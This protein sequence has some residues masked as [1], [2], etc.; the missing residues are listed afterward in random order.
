MTKLKHFGKAKL[1]LLSALCFLSITAAQAQV[2]K[3][4]GGTG[5]ADYATISAAFTAINSGLITGNI[6]LNVISSTTEPATPVQLNASTV[7]SASYTSVLIKPTATATINSAASP[8]SGKGVI[9]FCGADN[10]TIDGAIAAGG[11]TQDLTIAIA[12]INV[13]QA[14]IRLAGGTTSPAF[15]CNNIT[16]K[17]CKIVGNAT[18]TTFTGVFG[19]AAASGYSSTTNT[20]TFSSAGTSADPDNL[21]ITNNLITKCYTGIY[22]KAT[23]GNLADNLVIKGNTIGSA[24]SGSEVLFRGIDV[25]YTSTTANAGGVIDGNDI[26]VKQSTAL[27]DIA[28]IQLSNCTNTI[29]RGNKLHDIINANTSGYG[30]YGIYLIVANSGVEISN[31]FIY[32]IL[33]YR[34]SS[35]APPTMSTGG[36]DHAIGVNLEVATNTKIWSNTINLYGAIPGTSNS[37]SADIALLSNTSVTGTDIRNNVLVN[38]QTTSTSSRV[39][40][41]YAVSGVTFTQSNYNIYWVGATAGTAPYFVGLLGTDRTNLAAWQG[42]T[43]K[44]GNSLMADPLLVS[45]TNLHITSSSSPAKAAGSNPGVYVDYD[46]QTRGTSCDIGADEF[47]PTCFAT[48]PVSVSGI[49]QFAANLSWSAANTAPS[50]GYDIYYSTSSTAP[51]GA[52]TPSFSGVSGLTQ[53][54]SGLTP[55]TLYYVWIR[56]NCGGTQ[57]TWS[58]PTQFTSLANPCVTPTANTAGPLTYGTVTSTSIPVTSF[59]AASPAADGY[60]V[61]YSTSSTLSSG[62]VDGTTY[63]AGNA[64]G[65][66]TVVQANATTAFTIS[67]LSAN[68]LYYIFIYSYNNSGCSGGPKY[69]ATAYSTSKLTCAAAATALAGTATGQTTA[70]IT[71]T[72]PTGASSWLLEYKPTSGST[73]TTASPAPTGSPYSLT[74]LS[75]STTYDIR[76]TASNASC[77]T[78]VTTTSAF[79]TVCGAV[80]AGW[81]EGFETVTPGSGAGTGTY[82]PNCW[83]EIGDWTSATGTVS[84]YRKPRTGNQ[85][86]Y[87]QWSADDWLFS[88]LTTLTGGVSYDFTY[89]YIA[90]NNGGSGTTAFATELKYGTA[91]TA[92]GMTNAI[93]TLT[94][95]GTT[96]TFVKVT[97]T[98][99]PATTG[100]YTVGIHVFVNSVTPNYISFDDISLTQT[101]PCPTAPTIGTITTTS[102]T[103][104]VPFTCTSCAGTFIAEYST[105]SGFTPGTGATAGGGTVTSPVSSTPITING[106]SPNTTYYVY[107]RNNCSGAFY[108]PNS[109]VASFTT[110]C[111][112]VAVGWTEGFE[113]VTPGSGAGTGTY[114]PTCWSEIGDWTSATGV[115]STYRQPRTGNQFIYTN[116]TADDWLFTAPTTLTA[117]VS[118]DFT[119]YYIVDNN[120]GTGTSAFST[121][122]KYGTAQTVAGMTNTITTLANVA[123]TSTYTKVTQSFTPSVSGDYSIGIHVYVNST[124]PNYFSFDD[125]SLSVTPACSLAPTPGTITTTPVSATI[126]FTCSACTGTFIAEYSTT[127]GFTPGTGATAGGGTVTTPV[128]SSP[129][130]LSSLSPNTTYYVYLRNNCSGSTYSPNSSVFSFTTPCVAANVPYSES[131]DLVTQPALPSCYSIE[132]TNADAN[133]WKTCTSTSLGNLTAVTPRSGTNQMGIAYNTGAAMNDWFF[134]PQLNLTGGTS[135]RLTFWARGYTGLTE[136]LEVKYGTAASSASMTSGTIL[137]T[138]SIVGGGVYTQYTADF[139]PASSGT[140][141]IGFHGLSASNQWYLFVDDIAVNLTPACP[142]TPTIGTP[143]VTAT[144][145]TLPFTCTSCSGTFI[146]EYS[147]SS[148]FTPGTG[149]TAGGGTVTAPVSGT[150]ITI[151]GLTPNTTYYAYVRN[152]CSGSNYSA[153]SSVVSFTTYL[154]CSTATPLSCGVAGS[155]SV[156]GATGATAYNFSGTSPNN[157]CGNATP[158]PEQF[159][160][161]TPA[162]TGPYK[163]DGVKTGTAN[164]S[165]LYKD[166]SLGCGPTGWTCLGIINNGGF[167]NTIT[168]TGGV[169]YLIIVDN[170]SAVN[171]ATGTITVTCPCS[172]TPNA[173]TITQTSPQYFCG[174]TSTVTL[175]ATGLSTTPGISYQWEESDDNGVSDP[176]A[177]AVGGSGA[178]TANYTSPAITKTLYYRL[179]STCSTSGLSATTAPFQAIQN[180][181][182]TVSITPSV[183]SVC[184]GVGTSVTL[185][186]T[187]STG[188]TYSWSNSLGST[189][190]VSVVPSITSTYTVSATVTAT[191]C[192]ATASTTITVNPAPPVTTGASVCPGGSATIS[193]SSTC[194][195][196]VN[197][198]T[199]YSGA[200][201]GATDPTANRIT[202]SLSN[203]TTCSFSSTVYNRNYVAQQFQV[204]VTGSYTL[205]MTDNTA[206]DGMAYITTGAFVPGNCAGGGTWIVGDDDGGTAGNEPLMT[207]TLTAGVTYT[208]VS[209][210]YALSSGTYTG[211]FS[212]TITPPSGG[213]I[214]LPGTVNMNWYTA[215]FGG[216]PVATGSTINP[217]TLSLVNSNISGTTIFYAA[218]SSNNTCRTATNFVVYNPPVVAPTASP[219]TICNGAASTISAGAT[220]GSNPITTYAWSSGLA[221][222]V[223][224]G[225]VAPTTNSSYTVTVTDNKSCTSTGTIAVNVITCGANTWL[226]GSSDWHTAGNWSNGF[227]P[228][229]CSHDV[230]IPVTPNNPV[231]ST[232]VNVG[233]VQLQNGTT[234]TLNANLNVCGNFSG[235]ASTVAQVNGSAR[236]V[237]SGSSAQQLS[238]KLEVN[239]LRLNN[240]A[241]ASLQAGASVD[242]FDAVELQTGVLSTGS[243]T[244]RFRSTSPSQ[245]AI[246]NNF[247]P[248]FTGSLSGNATAQRFV[249]VGG[250]NQHYFGTPVTNATFGQLGATGVPGYVLPTYNCDQTQ[251]AINSPYGTVY[252][253]HDDKPLNAQCLYNGWEVKI[254]GTTQAG[255]GYSTFLSNGVFSITGN[256]NQG[257]SYS[258]NGM[259]NIGWT[260][261]TLQTYGFVPAAYE[262]GWHIVANP[263]LAP[264]TLNGHTPDFDAA[265]IWVTSGPFSGSYQPIPI[266]GGSIAPFQGFIVHRSSSSSVN[267]TFNKSECTTSAGQ[268][269]YKQ[270]SQHAMNIQ[271]SGNGFNDITY[272]EFNS[273]ATNTYDVGYD[274]RKP[275]SVLGQPTI[276]TF[277]T[278]NAE[279]L[280]INVNRS[281]DETPNVPMNFI[282]G[283]NGTFTFTADGVNSFDP[284]SYVFLEDKQT[285]QWIDLRQNA[286]YTFQSTTADA[287]D[288]F[289]L[290]FTPAA[291]LSASDASCATMGQ[292]TIEQPG[293]AN[294]NYTVSNQNNVVIASGTLNQNNSV[295]VS[296][297]AGVYQLT[298]VDNSGY[299]VVKNVQV[300]GVQTIAA[301][302]TADKNTV[303][304]AQDV[305]FT[306][307]TANA[308]TTEWNFGDGATATTA[309]ATH[310]YQSEGV[311]TVS[312]TVTNADGCSSTVQQTITVTAKEA[313]GINNLD[314][315]A[316]RM[317]SNES[318]I[319]IDFSKVKQVK[320]SIAIYNVLGQ[321]LLEDTWTK[322]SI[323]TKTL[324][325]L[326][327]A[328]ILVHVNNNGKM[329]TEKLF[330]TGTK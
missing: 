46:A 226:G 205:E 210:T 304:T 107:L 24:T 276:F 70:T 173:G 178:T 264:L 325:N 254:S 229:L 262:S 263:Y 159:F 321:K 214:M 28:G 270:A 310:Q 313:T 257:A 147:T 326:D 247:G 289:V 72:N 40:A 55:S 22:V 133:V 302:M 105:S 149:A 300:N 252:Q 190:S 69:F 204:S 124:T 139:I 26:Q 322:S 21:T 219:V 153:N 19:I 67:S 130:S 110:P 17:N 319:F 293:T 216:S 163:F 268:T 181:N 145:A 106:L 51:T 315:D 111:A 238:G 122:L 309:T 177:N 292:I 185:S 195:G 286:T 158:G 297:T 255:R 285:G 218:C 114:L 228:T 92:A 330:I 249:P 93:T 143:A 237:L 83:S 20:S 194:S 314:K 148:G 187:P 209:T 8:T 162:V 15:G 316:I 18:G 294:W 318:N 135:Y 192:S 208:L 120:A 47:S 86:I 161:F 31:N 200:W 323:Y 68:T 126:P 246:L 269:F 25:Q 4:V 45:S 57:S 118:Y 84:T 62:P 75:A 212:W 33:G 3:T 123:T 154:D 301:A 35:T 231:V 227:V 71:W 207:T 201:N 282:P 160:S 267:F 242:V 217:V 284:T 127:S 224:S 175:N 308:A 43:T 244:L 243:A 303:E 253:W 63:A 156:A 180:A 260:S 58:G 221:G 215:S 129:I 11:S 265:A 150:P 117:G 324:S 112:P 251:I 272:V 290:H 307:T 61:V 144:S 311:Y 191:T 125:I 59:P 115:V 189:Q 23:S 203:S 73:W 271:V 168:L 233:N 60:L 295:N 37:V 98:F 65:G 2:T 128:S 230:I 81:S 78:L 197:S 306:S 166:A 54:L 102:T 96:S 281:I 277:N 225:S 116:W 74:G 76:L 320:A 103:A 138:I 171:S 291:E 236:L 10:V 172:G 220:A 137:S 136:Q 151:S 174:T 179:K 234:L 134:L 113:T 121:E 13:T 79:T 6:T 248:G 176:W 273:D 250:T 328:Y 132:N 56:S 274:N 7:G 66:G 275:L 29:V 42:A 165:T 101:P 305:T 199:T 155:Y 39:V 239:T 296:A 283:A 108:S 213:Q 258:V 278:N 64:L 256:I 188:A 99:T 88:P 235:G 317:W 299:T 184:S 206:F 198:G 261:N 38:T 312:L 266:T 183:S 232:A 32:N 49:T 85:F 95:V 298:L 182:P 1:A 50:N 12:G 287:H 131:F 16:I 94:N 14:A 170:Q 152:N 327:A 80:A 119:Y 140:Y 279:R 142:T 52:T 48:G 329:T 241:G 30:A 100:D 169:T 280:S 27:I 44:D 77:G 196:F 82:L 91:Q 109:T 146:A 193:T 167:S 202:T 90:D 222:N 53:G 87:T 141:N 240:A 9:E 41:V 186:A 223:S 164:V 36:P 259:N 97:G 104:T 5:G 34:W 89:Y 288:R 245:I 211:A 157:S